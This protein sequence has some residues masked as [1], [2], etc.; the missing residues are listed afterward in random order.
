MKVRGKQS[1]FHDFRRWARVKRT[2]LKKENVRFQ[3][4]IFRE[5]IYKNHFKPR[6]LGGHLNLFILQF[7][8]TACNKKY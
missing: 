8:A 5:P 7:L 3:G 4:K 1:K 6:G 2:F